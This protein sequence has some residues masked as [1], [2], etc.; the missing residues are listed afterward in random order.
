MS[1]ESRSVTNSIRL[2]GSVSRL[3]KKPTSVPA[4]LKTIYRQ[5]PSLTTSTHIVNGRYRVWHSIS[6]RVRA[7]KAI[8]FPLSFGG[9]ADH[10]PQ[11]TCPRRSNSALRA[12]LPSQLYAAAAPATSKST[13][14]TE[15]RPP[16]QQ[17]QAETTGIRQRLS[18]S[19]VTSQIQQRCL[20]R[21]RRCRKKMRLKNSQLLRCPHLTQ[22]RTSA[23]SPHPI[24]AARAQVEP[25]TRKRHGRPASG[26]LSLARSA[27]QTMHLHV[28]ARTDADKRGLVAELHAP[29]IRS[30][31]RG[32]CGEERARY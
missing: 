29:T 11:Q 9:W 4:V 13:G 25:A 14:L 10:A 18:A 28:F 5:R 17:T 1:G 15:R 24:S 23:Q 7:T 21:R 3:M 31:A 12:Q 27:A 16:N 32:D 22:Q 26:G 6:K 30:I 20:L 2:H 8:L 19:V